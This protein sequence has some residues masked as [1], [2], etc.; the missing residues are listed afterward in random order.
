MTLRRKTYKPLIV[1]YGTFSSPFENRQVCFLNEWRSLIESER[2]ERLLFGARAI[3]FHDPE[4][5]SFLLTLLFLPLRFCISVRR[6]SPCTANHS[7]SPARTPGILVLLSSSQVDFFCFLL[8]S[9]V[10]WGDQKKMSWFPGEIARGF[11]QFS[12]VCCI[13]KPSGKSLI[14]CDVSCFAVSMDMLA[15]CGGGWNSS[16]TSWATQ[17]QSVTKSAPCRLGLSGLKIYL[18]FF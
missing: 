4:E 13:L 18:R 15:D 16:S 10:K 7:D 5:V 1:F 17:L 2:E 12:T 11:W 9:W 3:R 8:W 6:V 14:V